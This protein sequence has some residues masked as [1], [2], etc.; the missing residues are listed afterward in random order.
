MRFKASFATCKYFLLFVSSPSYYRQQTE[1]ANKH[2]QKVQ[3][4]QYQIQLSLHLYIDFKLNHV[5]KLQT[6]FTQ[7]S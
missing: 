4:K 5:I 1:R 6:Q 3:M 7:V 2:D